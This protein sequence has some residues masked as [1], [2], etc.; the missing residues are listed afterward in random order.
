MKIG[1]WTGAIV[2]LLIGAS[3][4]PLYGESAMSRPLEV[5]PEDQRPGLL[6]HYRSLADKEASLYRID[7]KPAF[8]L[9]HSSPHPR[10]PAG[11]FEVV[12]TGMLNLVDPPPLTFDAFVCGDVTMEVDGVTVLQGRGESETAQ[13]RSKE[14]LN[15]PRGLYP[16]RI[17]YRSLTGLPARL[18]IGWQG[19]TFAARATPGL[20]PR[21]S[22][23]RPIAACASGSVGR[24]GTGCGGPAR[25]R[26]LSQRRVPRRHRV[27][28]R[29]RAGGRRTAAQPGLAP[30]VAG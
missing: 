2:V 19:R 20:A 14:P 29:S 11:P 8:R 7:A 30:P 9:G 28:S 25:M 21:A 10:I 22:A 6:A 13:V 23:R 15:R 18:Q 4:G 26:P 24:E 12:W 17:R 27:A 5:E 1:H 16:L 3:V